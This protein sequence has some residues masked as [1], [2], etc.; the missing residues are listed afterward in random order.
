M[1]LKDITPQPYRCHT[2]QCCPTVFEG[3]NGNLVIVGKTLDASTL[4]Q[5]QHK[6]AADEY[7]I[8][9][10]AGLIDGLRK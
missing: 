7:A 4:A 1:A 3:D 8:E 2:S 9:V 10:P 6:I 5:V